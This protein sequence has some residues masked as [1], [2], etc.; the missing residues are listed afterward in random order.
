MWQS[1]HIDKPNTFELG[2]LRASAT[3]TARKVN[4]PAADQAAITNV[5]GLASFSGGGGLIQTTS[6]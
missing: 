5:A 2:K 6:G 4:V 3:M 1:L